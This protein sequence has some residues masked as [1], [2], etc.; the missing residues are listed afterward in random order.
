[1]LVKGRPEPF[2][3]HDTNTLKL[4][5]PP[6]LNPLALILS[7]RQSKANV[8]WEAKPADGRLFRLTIAVRAS[9]APH[10]PKPEKPD[11][12][13]FVRYSGTILHCRLDEGLLNR[14]MLS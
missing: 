6:T 2:D 4:V 3:H 14:D 10:V 12:S 5:E 1:M 9:S 8:A 7:D 13:G 11:S